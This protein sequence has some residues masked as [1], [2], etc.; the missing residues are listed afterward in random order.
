[1]IKILITI[2]I[3]IMPCLADVSVSIHTFNNQED[4]TTSVSFDSGISC[5]GELLEPDN[6]NMM[7]MGSVTGSC[8][9]KLDYLNP[10]VKYSESF[11]SHN[12]DTKWMNEINNYQIHSVET[13]EK[14]IYRKD[15]ILLILYYISYEN[16]Y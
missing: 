8:S 7:V 15:Y 13:F 3:L 5:I 11:D 12:R 14:P 10:F 4:L 16:P 1:M 2:M 9:S 6:I